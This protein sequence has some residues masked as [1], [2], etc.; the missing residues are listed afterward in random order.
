MSWPK[1]DAEPV[2]LTGA[3]L[4]ADLARLGPHFA[5]DM[6]PPDAA[7]DGAWRPFGELLD[8]LDVRVAEVR[9]ALAAAS[10]RSPDEVE[11]RVAVSLTQLGL[12]GRLV[13]PAL[14]VAVLTGRLLDLDPA[15]LRW[16]PGTGSAVALSVPADALATAGSAGMPREERVDALAGALADT[17]LAGPVRM[18]VEAAGRFGVSS[19]VLWGN[20]ASVVHGARA[21][22][23]AGAPELLGPAEALVAA[24]LDRPPLRGT[25]E[26]GPGPEF[27]RRSCC[28][29]YRLVPARAERGP[30][31]SPAGICGDCVLERVATEQ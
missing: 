16:Q 5:L 22:I 11:R 10:H 4:P 13:C 3:G 28:L 23:G 25:S 17:V 30:T 20:V 6:H 8:A 1:P 21:L 2:P 31:G 26:G 18:L 14:G 27:R 12:T 7:P 29:I 9:A 15:R 19:Q 24:L